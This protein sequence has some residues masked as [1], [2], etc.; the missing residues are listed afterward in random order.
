MKKIICK[1]L[2]FLLVLMMV[3]TMI[4]A[5]VAQA[6]EVS[7]Y[8]GKKVSILGDSISTYSGVSNNTAA[9][10]TIGVNKGFYHN[11]IYG[12]FTQSDT[13]WQQTLDVLGMDLL[14]DNAWGGACIMNARP[15]QENVGENSVGYGD[16]CVNLHND[17]TG[18]TPD[19]IFVFMG[20]N[21]FSYFPSTLG[22]AEAVN[23]NTLIK[24]NGN[25][26]FTYAK[27]TTTCEAYAIMLHKMQQRYPNAEI[28]CM[29]L[30]PR[31]GN[32]S[33]PTAFNASIKTIAAKYGC[34]VVDLENCGITSDTDTFDKYIADQKVHPNKAGMD[35]MTQAV[36]NAMLGK[37]TPVH[38]ITYNLISVQENNPVHAVLGGSYSVT[39][40]GAPDVVKVTM[41]GKDITASSWNGT[42]VNI[43]NVTGDVVIKAESAAV[44]LSQIKKADK[45]VG[46]PANATNVQY[47][48]DL[49]NSK[50]V[51]QLNKKV[52]LDSEYSG[53]LY[54]WING[55]RKLIKGNKETVNGNRTFTLSDG[56]K[57]TFNQNDI[58][59]G[60]N[61]VKYEKG[62][63]VHPDAGNN[64][65]RYIVYDVKGLNVNRF[66]ALVGGTGNNVTDPNTS[67]YK[68]SFELWGSK[69]SAY[70]KNDFQRLAYVNDLRVYLMGEFDID[71][72]GYNYIKLVVK[73]SDGFVDNSACA[74]AWA[75]ACVYSTSG[76]VTPPPSTQPTTPATQPSTP[77]T[78]PSTQ[79]STEPSTE[80]SVEPSTEPSVEPT[81]EPSAEPTTE[82]SVEPTTQPTQ[83]QITTKPADN[84]DQGG[85]NS[86]VIW[87]VIAAVVVAGGV[88]A[89]ILLIKKRKQ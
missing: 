76:S 68:I 33:Q 82:P 2:S 23:Y 89:G 24:D 8:K 73:M 81:T 17:K 79:P 35:L 30:M 9:N 32:V 1:T 80:P 59:L 85:D 84:Q 13:W 34:G 49:Y 83:G 60:Y 21:D 50:V 58:A 74:A 61:A 40:T 4:P 75:D 39:L 44:E 71:I 7:E 20:T 57:V 64:A 70:N 3:L 47:L 38:D 6:K 18:V 67:K 56:S 26:S 11:N 87:I 63:G 31:R 62:L 29:T 52:T 5:P 10:S 14:V 45:P 43:P 41:G 16:R 37:E 19:V 77:A 88:T 48:S 22:T 46:R 42:T 72:T 54:L 65:A 12:G 66:Y 25:G 53:N 51:D 27:P 86:L 69:S 55:S 78:Q 15:E 28:F 36:V